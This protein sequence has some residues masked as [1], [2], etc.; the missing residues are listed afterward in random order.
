MSA[1]WNLPDGLHPF[2]V[3]HNGPAARLFDRQ[4]R[5]AIAEIEKQTRED[6]IARCRLPG[7]A[8]SA[9]LEY[10]REIHI[11][12]VSQYVDLLEQIDAKLWR[13]T[14]DLWLRASIE[15]GKEPA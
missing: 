14:Y 7:D 15:N 12:S 4:W 1:G 10:C 8:R 13:D 9:Y 3:P 5:E 2:D 11:C 6:L